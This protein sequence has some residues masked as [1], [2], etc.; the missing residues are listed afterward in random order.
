MLEIEPSSGIEP[1]FQ[2][3]LLTKGDAMSK[4]KSKSI[5]RYEGNDP[6]FLKAC[7]LAGMTLDQITRRQGVKWKQGRGRAWQKRDE[8]K[9]VLRPSK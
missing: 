2:S 4:G 6:L 7:E 5:R 3:V 1:L 9:A 8:A